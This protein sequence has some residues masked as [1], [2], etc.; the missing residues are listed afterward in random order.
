MS[1]KTY[2]IFIINTQCP[3]SAQRRLWSTGRM[4]RLIWVF[5]GRAVILLVLSW[6]KGCSTYDAVYI[7]EFWLLGI[8]VSVGRKKL[9]SK[10]YV[11]STKMY[12]YIPQIIWTHWLQRESNCDANFSLFTIST[13]TVSTMSVATILS[14]ISIDIKETGSFIRF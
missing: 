14:M 2:G 8:I 5:A 7:N 3:L 12:A 11:L 6:W 10:W 9:I 4:P 1:Y 13:N